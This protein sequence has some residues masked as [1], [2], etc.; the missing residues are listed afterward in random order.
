MTPFAFAFMS[1][2]MAS[3]TALAAYCFYRI[4]TGNDAEADSDD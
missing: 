1:V 3:V 2:S 4:L